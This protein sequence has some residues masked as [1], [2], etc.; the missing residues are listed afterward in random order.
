[1]IEERARE[2]S[3]ALRSGEYEQGTGL[4]G[5][6]N[7]DGTKAFCCLGVACELAVKAGKVL[8]PVLGPERDDDDERHHRAYQYGDA[9]HTGLLPPEVQRYF[10]FHADDGGWYNNGMIKETLEVNGGRQVTALAAANDGGVTFTRIAEF[11]DKHW[12]YL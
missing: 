10:G 3:A 9:G 5:R 8:P 7:D 12:Q 2:L 1:M 6:L 4:L 11:I